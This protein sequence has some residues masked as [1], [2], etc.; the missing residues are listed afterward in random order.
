MRTSLAAATVLALA[1]ALLSSCAVG[2]DFH[3]PTASSAQSYT[4]TP[5]PSQ[6]GASDVLAGQAQVLDPTQSL[7]A[8]WWVVFHNEALDG[9]VRLGL[10]N[11]PSIQAARQ[12]LKA[13]EETYDAQTAS[14]FFPSAN[15]Q[16]GATRQRLS[17]ATFGQPNAP[18]AI[19]NL[20]SGSVGVTYRPDVFGGSRRIAEGY[21]AAV[22]FQRYELEAAYL[23]LTANLVTTAIGQASLRA[24]LAATQQMLASQQST[25]AIVES[26]AKAGAAS[27]ADVLAQQAQVALTQAQ[28]PPLQ[29][30]LSQTGHRLAVL[31]GQ[32][33]SYDQIPDFELSGFALP[34]QLPVSLPSELVHN[35]PDIQAAEAQLHQ[36]SANVGV[37]TAN[38]YPQ[39]NLS[40]SIGAQ[41]ATT[42]TLLD[43]A[44]RA[45]SLGAGVTQPLFHAGELL[46]RRKAAQAQYEAARAS[47]QG[48]VLAAFQQVADTLRAIQ[49]DATALQAAA[50]ANS[51]A[52]QSLAL[53]QSQYVAGAVSYLTLL[54]AQ[55]VALD[56]SRNL[57]QAQALRF[58]DSATLYAALGG[59]WWNRAEGTK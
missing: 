23:S 8:D 25:L 21:Q 4:P 48:T 34:G 5:V 36:A 30:A 46:A 18:A 43:A 29:K 35:R 53:T 2:P 3:A 15:A 42:G 24:Q 6:T 56:A 52:Q 49:W 58:T 33:P 13:A 44:S 54:N 28:L 10:D 50:E 27:K 12:A 9:L 37:A 55:R 26:R 1:T 47:Y 57:V 39:L 16:L 32:S 7:P 41:S 17:P 51:V 19:Y 59:G 20:Y 38:L 11:S 31:V 40:A 22:D 45:W 14:L